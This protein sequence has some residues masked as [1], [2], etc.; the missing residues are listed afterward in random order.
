VQGAIAALKNQDFSH[1]VMQLTKALHPPLAL[2]KGPWR[3][4]SQ[5]LPLMC[6]P[7][8]VIMCSIVRD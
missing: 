7:L 2:C 4:Q 3:Q 5:H 1:I 6:L 8:R